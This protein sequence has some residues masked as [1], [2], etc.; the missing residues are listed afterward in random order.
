MTA[1]LSAARRDDV[2]DR[3]VHLH[4]G[5]PI[6]N[7]CSITVHDYVVLR[8]AHGVVARYAYDRVE[9]TLSLVEEAR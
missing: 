3:A 7:A 1:P 9:D 6:R 8:D 4:G 5:A 2:I